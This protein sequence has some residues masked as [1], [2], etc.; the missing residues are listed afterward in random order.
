M[1]QVNGNVRG[2]CCYREDDVFKVMGLDKII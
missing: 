1:V 2:N